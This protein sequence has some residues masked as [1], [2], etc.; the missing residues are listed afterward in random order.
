MSNKGYRRC[1][2][3]NDLIVK[4]FAPAIV[5]ALEKREREIVME[6]NRTP[7]PV[8]IQADGGT[9]PS[10]Y[11][12]G[13]TYHLHAKITANGQL[14]LSTMG[15]SDGDFRMV[16]TSIDNGRKLL[17]T[18]YIYS[19]ILTQPALVQSQYDRIADKAQW[20][21]YRN[22]NGNTRA[23]IGNRFHIPDGTHS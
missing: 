11:I 8:T 5:I 12:D 9:G 15:K 21:V 19:D 10:R 6:T 20:D 7:T 23:V 17:V 4:R 3:Q 13:I 22:E 2:S 1:V 18:R 16:F 14:T